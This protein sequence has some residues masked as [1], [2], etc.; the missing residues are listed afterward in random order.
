MNTHAPVCTHRHAHTRNT[1]VPLCIHTETFT[2]AHACTY[3]CKHRHTHKYEPV[4]TQR[5]I[6]THTGIPV[7]AQT[8]TLGHA[9][10]QAHT[11]AIGDHY[12][13]SFLITSST[14]ETVSLTEVIWSS[15]MDCFNEF[16]ESACPLIPNPTSVLELLT[17]YSLFPVGSGDLN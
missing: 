2:H 11:C 8:H 16:Q 10:T 1:P 13:L 17:C 5:D 15:P 14:F 9:H 7:C 3:A 6:H 4:H 12:Q